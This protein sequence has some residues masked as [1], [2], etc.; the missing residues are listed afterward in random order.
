MKKCLAI[1]LSLMLLLP[2]APAALAEQGELLITIGGKSLYDGQSPEEIAAAFGQPRLVTS[3]A[4]GGQAYTYYGEDFADYLYLETTADGRIV[5]YGTV[6][7]GFTSPEVS[8]GDVVQWGSESIEV[9]YDT[10][11]VLSA[12][13][14]RY[15]WSD[16]EQYQRRFQQDEDQYLANFQRHTTLMYNAVA[17]QSGEFSGF[18]FNETLFSGQSAVKRE[19]QRFL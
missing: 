18:E 4:F 3:S 19:R 7:P 10:N 9:D 11:Q 14:S 15:T 12:C 16:L 1:L 13:L 17:F 5:L 6:T 8:Y 2:M